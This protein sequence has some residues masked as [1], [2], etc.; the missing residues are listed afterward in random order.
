MKV[1]YRSIYNKQANS[2]KE[3]DFTHSL[4][5]DSV[6]SKSIQRQKVWRRRNNK[7][8]MAIREVVVV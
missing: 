4:F 3:F 5:N 7:M 8:Q 2:V 6:I 1:V